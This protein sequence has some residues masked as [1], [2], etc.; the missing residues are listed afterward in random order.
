VDDEEL[1]MADSRLR[2]GGVPC[3]RLAAALGV[4]ALASLAAPVL[5]GQEAPAPAP[6][7]VRAFTGARILDGRGGPPI[8][9]GTLVVRDGH[10][11]AIGPSGLVEIPA[12]A[13]RTDVTG[14][15]LIPGLVNTHGHVGEARGLETGPQ[16]YTE[17]NVLDQLQMYA[18]YGI[19]T[20]FSLGGDQEAG[21]RLRD[22]QAT[23][24]LDRSRLFVAGP[25][26][27][28][29]TSAEARQKVT[30][31]A[32]RKV[33][34]VKIRVDDNLGTSKKMSVPVY[35]TVIDV[36]HRHGLR[37][38][39]HIYYLEDAILLMRAG[40]DYIAH[41]I[42]DRE[43]DDTLIALLKERDVCVC[44][45]LTREVSTY[46][47]ESTPDFFADPFFRRYADETVLKG[48]QEPARQASVRASRSAQTYKAQLEVASRNLKKLADAGVRIAFGTDTGPVGRFQ[49]YFEHL[50]MELMAKA[51]LTPQ[52]ILMSAMSDAAR[53]VGRPESVG[54]L[55]PGAWAD[56][57][58]LTANPLDDIRN[59]RAIESVWIAGNRIADRPGTN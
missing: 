24:A 43:V 33:D 1:Q 11:E 7:R 45:T 40:V 2:I 15:T 21:F 26:V 39:A 59:T 37:V 28:A 53:C 17:A 46:V 25:V 6:A 32:T 8:E 54:V 27:T 9:R 34:V 23:P 57:L 31:L 49:G 38:A 41:S 47:Y 18:R 58:I 22:A 20:V 3:H 44:P 13:E 10:V 14:R 52:Q 35:Q 19:T 16:V 4:A 50:E 30:D 56:F 51:G 48:L 29:D 36:A 12:G 42:R 5:R 55:K